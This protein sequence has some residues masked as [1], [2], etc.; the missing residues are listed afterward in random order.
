MKKLLNL[1]GTKLISK[2]LQKNIKGGMPPQNCS[3]DSDCASF[4]SCFVC[5]PIGSCFM[6]FNNPC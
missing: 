4:G 3:T 1:D 6:F 5:L 2:N